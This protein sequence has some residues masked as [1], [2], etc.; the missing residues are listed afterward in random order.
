VQAAVDT[1]HHLIVAHE[2][3]NVGNDRGQLAEMSKK[4][5]AV[6][7]T[8]ELDVVADRGYFDSEE[9]L[10]CDRAGITVTLP[11]P[12]TSY[13][14]AQGRFGK[15]DFRYVAEEDVYVCSA[16]QRLTYRYTNEENGLARRHYWTNVCQACPIK[17]RCTTGKERRITRWEHEDVLEA[18]QRRLD[19]NPQAMRQRRE[20]VE[21]PFGTIKAWMGATHFLMKRLKNVRTEMALSVL[22]Y[23]LTRVMN[24][25][26]IRPLMAAI[27]A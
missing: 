24:I 10:A 19:E 8:E 2:V 27:R 21:H 11:K 25:I 16:D 4:A 6:L 18:V 12:M 20:T 17:E 13:A 9:I 23:N 7:D 22:A 15:Q 14:K 1:E 5:K 26:G 3:I